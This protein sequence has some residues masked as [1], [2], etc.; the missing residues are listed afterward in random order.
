MPVNTL[1]MVAGTTHARSTSIHERMALPLRLAIPLMLTVNL[2]GDPVQRSVEYGRAGDVPLLMDFSAPEGQGPFPAIVI[3]HGGGWIGG[4]RQFSVEP[5][6]EPLAKSG[7]AWFSISYRL[8][9]DLLQFGVA[10][11]D[12]QTALQFVRSNAEKYNIDPQRIAVLGESAGA[13]LAFLAVER[14]PR[15]VAAVVAMY[16]PTDLVSL[17]ENARAIPDSLR[18]MVRAAGMEGLIRGYLK[19]MSPI[20]HVTSGLPPFLLVH[21]TADTIVPF[22]QSER[23]LQKLR[24]A[25][26]SA[27]LITVKGGGHG[28]RGWERSREHATYRQAVIDWLQKT[29]K[30]EV[31]QARSVSS[32]LSGQR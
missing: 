16:P 29:L 13:H 4:H 19:E 17:A 1:E 11:D 27:E 31:R 32:Q 7:F 6:F 14:D 25:G 23:M 5:L 2:I 20:D 26:N 12:V 30:R 18:Q 22:E 21:G 9:T 3:V 15:S 10:V 24:A 28:L 8:A